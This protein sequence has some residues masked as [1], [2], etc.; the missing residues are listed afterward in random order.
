MAH[1]DREHLRRVLRGFT[2]GM[3]TTHGHDGELHGRPMLVAG[4]EDDGEIAF[5]SHLDS[6]KMEEIEA[7]PRCA[8]L[9]QGSLRWASVTG[10]AR[11]ERDRDRIHRLWKPHWRLWFP[12]G[13]DDPQ[14]ALVVVSPL[15]AEYWDESG[16]RVLSFA[17]K[18][19]NR[20][21]QRR[22]MAPVEHQQHAKIT[23]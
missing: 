20:V 23:W 8:V 5:C 16:P 9:L 14:L 10:H 7:D 22:P 11:I 3:L 6:S 21:L 2:V 17:A 13:R 18:A 4:V 1:D 12:G 15:Q 19:V